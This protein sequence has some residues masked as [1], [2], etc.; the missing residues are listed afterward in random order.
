MNPLAEAGY[1]LTTLVF[2]ILIFLFL[3]RLVLE[4]AKADT[5]NPISQF[6]IRFT[7]PLV[8]PLSKL[9]PRVRSFNLACFVVLI[10]LTM[11]KLFLTQLIFGVGFTNP[12]GLAVWSVG[13]LIGNLISL[14]FVTILI[15]VIISWIQ[16]H[17]YNPA[18][19]LIFRINEP[20]MA[21]ARRWIP[22]AGGLDFS[23][24]IVIVM[25]MLLN[26][27]ISKPIIGMGQ[28]LAVLT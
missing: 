22:A 27:L 17:T 2:D 6:I 19:S 8:A 1:F 24:I 3:I 16:P 12:L 11:L 4:F 18:I 10:L 26:I 7:S 23:P 14:L 5:N 28:A 9:L 25:L 21:P 20:I 13:E 15:Q